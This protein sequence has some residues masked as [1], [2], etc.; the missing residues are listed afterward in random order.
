MKFSDLKFQN[1]PLMDHMF[2]NKIWIRYN[3]SESLQVAA[4][5][6]MQGVHPR[7][8]HCDGFIK[9]LQDAIHQEMTKTEH[10][11]LQELLPQTKQPEA[12]DGEIQTAAIKLEAIS[13]TIGYGNGDARIKTKA[14]EIRVRL[15]IRIEIKE[16]MMRL[17]TNAK[18]PPGRFIP[19]GLVQTVG[20]EV[21]KKMLCTQND[22]LTNFRIVPVFGIIPQALEH[23]ITVEF[24]DETERHMTVNNFI[25]AKDCIKGV[26]TTNRANDLGKVFLLSDA[27]GIFEA[28]TFV[29]SVMKQLYESG[30][31]P[32]D[33]IHPNFNPCRRGDAPRTSAT[34]QSYATALANLGNPQDDT[35]PAGGA[36][37]PPQPAKR[38]IQM[39]YV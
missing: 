26:E 14:F 28:R 22:F 32:Q 12:E 6:F 38:N 25:L 9:N 18:I 1:A 8:T 17:G 7:V 2:K 31:T 3:Q 24:D 4:L 33:M 10:T 23:M 27:T 21:Y 20:V 15:E 39:V 34:F 36:A 37:A 29:D 13:R 11:K 5:G 16:I 35:T 30:R 19:Y